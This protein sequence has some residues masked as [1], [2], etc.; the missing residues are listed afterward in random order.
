MILGTADAISV[1]SNAGPRAEMLLDNL[2]EAVATGSDL[3]KQVLAFARTG[4]VPQE[5]LDL[6]K[7][8]AGSMRL[9]NSGRWPR[10]T[11]YNVCYPKLLRQK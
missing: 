8:I 7:A 6:S 9:I 4:E 1:E 2:R 5:S 11:S 10:I 3:V